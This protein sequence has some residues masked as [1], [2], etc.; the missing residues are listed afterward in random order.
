MLPHDSGE[1]RRGFGEAGAG[2]AQQSFAAE[3][4][5]VCT[6]E[7]AAG[8]LRPL[9]DVLDEMREVFR[10]ESEAR[11]KA[12]VR[13]AYGREQAV[14][15]FEALGGQAA[16]LREAAAALERAARS[17]ALWRECLRRRRVSAV[18]PP[19]PRLSMSRAGR[20]FT[21]SNTAASI[22]AN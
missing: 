20:S 9:A 14:R 6:V 17:A 3:G 1:A 19:A 18:K 7:P 13:E 10:E 15:A 4:Y 8:K 21:R 2:E 16:A 12:L 5:A 22:S 11:R